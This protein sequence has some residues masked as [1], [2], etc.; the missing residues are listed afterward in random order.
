M[1]SLVVAQKPEQQFR[2]QAAE[3]MVDAA[4]MTLHQLVDEFVRL[5]NVIDENC[6]RTDDGYGVDFNDTAKLAD[7][8]RRIITTASRARFGVDF[9]PFDRQG[10]D[11]F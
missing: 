10:R 8:Q 5:S 1:N 7:R 3:L 9:Q 6:T 2:S 11:D 4:N